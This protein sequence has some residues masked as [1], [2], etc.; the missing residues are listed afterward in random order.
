MHCS[1]ASTL[2]SA[3]VVLKKHAET[4]HISNRTVILALCEA[5]EMKKEKRC[6]DECRGNTR[7]RLVVPCC[8]TD[9]GLWSEEVQTQKQVRLV[10][11]KAQRHLPSRDQVI[12]N[13][14]RKIHQMIGSCREVG[15]VVR[16]A[17][18]PLVVTRA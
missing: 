11:A 5:N 12:L 13:V 4:R 10:G 15:G 6:C 1:A 2:T 17:G 3:T 9:P 18:V 7:L 16:W 14:T 8:A